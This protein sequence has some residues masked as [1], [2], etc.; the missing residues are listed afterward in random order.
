M[1]ATPPSPS[2]LDNFLK[3]CQSTLPDADLTQPLRIRCIGW[4]LETSTT[5]SA[6]V[7]AGDKTGTFSVPWLWE[8][9]PDTKPEIGEYVV[10]SNFD[11][12]PQALLQ[13]MALELLTFKKIDA[14]H[15]ALDGPSMR[16]L[17]VWRGIHTEYWNSLLAPLGRQI[18]DDMPVVA[19]RFACV[20]PQG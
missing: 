16:D 14:T 1:P 4:N 18:E 9:H 7:V 10:L 2:I 17:D 12:E 3:E 5:I 11:G 6:L 13:V 20:Y 15:T 8:S 19:E